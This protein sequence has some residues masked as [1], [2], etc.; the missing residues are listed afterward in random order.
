MVLII[1]CSCSS[2]SDCIQSQCALKHFC[3]LIIYL[4][5]RANEEDEDSSTINNDNNSLAPTIPPRMIP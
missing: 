2:I 4:D 1:H 3:M 5:K